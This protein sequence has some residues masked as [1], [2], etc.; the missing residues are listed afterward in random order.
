MLNPPRKNRPREWLLKLVSPLL[1]I[2]LWGL[3]PGAAIAQAEVK[4][5][6]AVTAKE[7][8]ALDTQYQE[9]LNQFFQQHLKKNP[10]QPVAGIESL[11]LRVRA[12]GLVDALAVIR[13]N[14]DMARQNT[15]TKEFDFLLNFLY[16]VNDTASIQV[17]TEHL[18]KLGDSAVLSR[19]Y[20][21]LAKYYEERQNWQAVQGALSRI[22]VRNLSVGDN[23]YY[24][25]LM[26]YAMQNLKEH[27]KSLQYYQ[28]IPKDSPYFA[29]AKLNEGSA[30][31]RQGWWTEAHMEFERAIQF[32]TDHP[33]DE[34]LRNRLLVV[35]GYSQ[36]HYEFYR[37]ARN[38][39][40]KVAVDSDST[41][42]A[43]MGIG[44]AAAYQKD[45]VGAANAFRLLTEKPVA[46]LS[47]DEAFLLLPYAHEET[48]N[49]DAAGLAYQKAVD[50]YQRKI[51]DLLHLQNRILGV[52]QNNLLKEIRDTEARAA[53]VF[54]G[55]TGIPAY[56]QRNFDN[57]MQMQPLAG[58]P[59]LEKTA[60]DLRQ[61][62]QNQLQKLTAQNIEARR[63]MLNSYLSQ[64]KFG[65]A[66]LYDAP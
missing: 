49:R 64:A 65:M 13:A 26:G 38:T 66:K 7:F 5:G 45:F 28:Q 44:L 23:H 52:S 57:L 10:Q 21:L 1:L 30:N 40:R 8:D 47:V 25:L 51:D 55:A 11:V 59:G 54:G 3:T 58:E 6:Q 9:F 27:R 16:Q 4:A 18:K 35:L 33:R 34:T 29:H 15:A 14:L 62:Y 12:A 42:K 39:L 37:D 56:M 20:F 31:L 41:N 48:G 36:L 60:R 24:Q 53:E 32:L 61:R 17:L 46:D 50:H 63:A 2:A 19:N 43:L 22:D